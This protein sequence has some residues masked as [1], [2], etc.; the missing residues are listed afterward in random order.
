METRR[1]APP[2][3]G[4]RPGILRGLAKIVHWGFIRPGYTVA[5]SHEIG[6]FCGRAAPQA[7]SVADS[8]LRAPAAA[9]LCPAGVRSAACRLA[10]PRLARAPAS[11]GARDLH[12]RGN[13][14]RP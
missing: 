3:S 5:S 11:R 9:F 4:E 7:T 6:P 13:P 12:A 10:E 14:L 2:Q 8:G 1:M